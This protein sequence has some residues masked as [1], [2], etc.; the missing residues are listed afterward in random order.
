LAGGSKIA[1]TMLKIPLETAV[2]STER[3]KLQQCRYLRLGMFRG[4]DIRLDTVKI[5][6]I[7]LEHNLLIGLSSSVPLGIH[8]LFSPNE[9]EYFY[10]DRAV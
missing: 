5:P 3:K 1:R 9:R 7:E 6:S 8:L 2:Y 4:F 10:S